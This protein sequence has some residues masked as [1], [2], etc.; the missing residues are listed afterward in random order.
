MKILFIAHSGELQGAGIALLNILKG[1]ILN[2]VTPIV[3]LPSKSVMHKELSSLGIKTYIVPFCLDTRPPK[4]NI[5]DLMLFLPRYIRTLAY[6]CLAKNKVKRIAFKEDVDIIHTN[7][8]V[9][10]WG[11]QIAKELSL[12]HV[13][14]VRECQDLGLNYV[15]LCGMNKLKDAMTDSNNVCLAITKAVF[16][17]HNLKSPKDRIVYD[18]VFSEKDI[19]DTIIEQKGNYFLYVGTLTKMKGVFD[20]VDAF[21]L[22]YKKCPEAELWLAGIDYENVKEY[23]KKH[24][25]RDKIKLLG[26]RKD[27]YNLMKKA[28]A[29]LVPSFFEGFGF[30]TAEAMVNGCLVIG[31]NVAGTKEQFDIGLKATG[32]EIALRFSNIEELVSQMEYACKMSNDDLIEILYNARIVAKDYTIENNTNNIL[33]IYREYKYE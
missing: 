9:I 31:R 4:R 29:L 2:N 12:P 27:I 24:S 23:I 6:R 32:K 14:H 7:T 28:R 18:G 15:P 17:H 25:C 19:D 11:A 22:L 13:W 21:S 33:E 26:F 8:S 1:V 20:A 5:R 3:V 10:H 30:I 16:E